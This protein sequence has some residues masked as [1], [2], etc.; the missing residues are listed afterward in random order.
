[1]RRCTKRSAQDATDGLSPRSGC[2]QR[3]SV[4]LLDWRVEQHEPAFNRFEGEAAENQER[5]ERA[6]PVR[7]ERAVSFVPQLGEL[8]R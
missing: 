2:P 7:E 1:M 8:A 6:L 3:P 5:A 4:R